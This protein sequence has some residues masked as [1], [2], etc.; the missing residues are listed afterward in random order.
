MTSSTH[1]TL[2]AK[3]DKLSAQ[4]LIQGIRRLF[5]ASAHLPKA[6]QK[7]QIQLLLSAFESQALQQGLNT[8]RIFN[9]IRNYYAI[10]S[11]S[12]IESPTTANNNI[13]ADA[14]LKSLDAAIANIS[15]AAALTEDNKPATVSKK[16]ARKINTASEPSTPP[17]DS[18]APLTSQASSEMVLHGLGYDAQ[19]AVL[20]LSEDELA[21]QPPLQRKAMFSRISRA[22]QMA[23][24]N[25]FDLIELLENVD[26]ILSMKNESFYQAI[27]QSF[28]TIIHHLN[29][30]RAKKLKLPLNTDIGRPRLID[31]NRITRLVEYIKCGRMAKDT[32]YDYSQ[33]LKNYGK[34]STDA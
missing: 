6:Q 20:L 13:N 3:L 34:Q 25:G 7:R 31:F 15:I 9:E 2:S 14:E 32:A 23:Q 26:S 28:F 19:L 17:V 29:P 16:L 12:E 1:D 27:N 33:R 5:N 4:K 30:R 21:L 11:S 24:R 8:S 18:G 10:S 22:K